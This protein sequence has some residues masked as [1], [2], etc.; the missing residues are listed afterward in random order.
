MVAGENAKRQQGYSKEPTP[1][2][3][4]LKIWKSQ[5]TL[6]LFLLYFI[7]SCFQEAMVH[8]SIEHRKQYSKK[9]K[10]H[11]STF[12]YRDEGKPNPEEIEMSR[13]ETH[14]F[15]TFPSFGLQSALLKLCL[16]REKC[17][18]IQEN[19]EEPAGSPW[20]G[21]WTLQN[22]HACSRL[23]R[24]FDKCCSKLDMVQAK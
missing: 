15:R 2:I 24:M 12:K 11:D 16:S 6:Q 3:L 14:V 19:P 13:I 22:Q 4:V 17:S 9:K 18:S 1:S 7:P 10:I 8:G 5:K 20:P 23:Q 21:C